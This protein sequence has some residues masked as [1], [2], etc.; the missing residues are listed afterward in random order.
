MPPDRLER[1][2]WETFARVRAFVAGRFPKMASIIAEW[3][4]TLR[5]GMTGKERRRAFMHAAHKR[6]GRSRVVCV[7]PGAAHLS[8]E[9]LVGLFLHEF[10][11]FAAGPSDT[12]ADAWVFEQFGILILYDGMADYLE[13]VP[14]A[15]IAARRI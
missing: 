8:K 10:G 9:F 2:L 1:K 5:D 12:K 7:W 4:P 3:C 14:A 15:V 6:R 13:Y 11:H